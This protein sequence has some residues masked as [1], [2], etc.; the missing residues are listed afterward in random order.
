[1]FPN[2]WWAIVE[3]RRGLRVLHP[4][5]IPVLAQSRRHIIYC[6]S[7]IVLSRWMSLMEGLLLGSCVRR[8]ERSI[9]RHGPYLENHFVQGR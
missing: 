7:K 4:T 6:R 8:R 1:M 3:V 5:V 2:L 9:S